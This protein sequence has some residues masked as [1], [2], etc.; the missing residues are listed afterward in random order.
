MT[1]LALIK[2]DI[3]V[4]FD[5]EQDALLHISDMSRE[6]VESVESKVKLED[7]IKVEI[8]AIEGKNKIKVKIDEE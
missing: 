6:R 7:Q 5:G 1:A 4:K 8:I 2:V 3:F